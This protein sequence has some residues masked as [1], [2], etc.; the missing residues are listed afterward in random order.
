MRRVVWSSGAKRRIELTTLLIV[1]MFHG[2]LLSALLAIFGARAHPS[3]RWLALLVLAATLLLFE[4]YSRWSGLIA[5]WPHMIGVFQPVWFAIGPLAYFYACS[6]VGRRFRRIH[7]TLFLPMVG[8][9]SWMMPFMLLPAET[10]L[11][12]HLD[13]SAMINLYTVFW[14]STAGCAYLA[15]RLL[16][17]VLSRSSTLNEPWRLGWLQSLMGVLI[18]YAVLDLTA[19][20]ALMMAG[21]YPS[22]VGFL[23]VVLLVGLI[24]AVALLVL[25]PDGL[26]ARSPWPGERYA[27]SRIPQTAA[28]ELITQLESI[29]RGQRPWLDEALDQRQLADL[30][31][32]NS[33]QLSQLLSQHLDASFADYINRYRIAEAQR[34]LIEQGA[35]KTML[36][37]GLA[38]GFGSSASFYRV[39]KKQVRMT[40]RDFLRAAMTTKVK[41]IQRSASD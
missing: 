11:R 25:L 18:A 19:T 22:V 26:L 17:S 15:R 29:M 14:V 32:V 20:I 9:I 37:I 33:H 5:A 35:D 41:S 6:L 8:V 30:L 36:E 4:A 1:M 38:A 24:Y 31:D 40:P 7:L 28:Q 34:L 39:F 10:K 21:T 12:T 16:I 27:R 3:N 23:S 13:A 2:A